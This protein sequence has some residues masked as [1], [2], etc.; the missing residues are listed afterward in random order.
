L[1]AFLIVLLFGGGAGTGYPLIELAAQILAL[2]LIVRA[3]RP[4]PSAINT[5]AS[6]T[7]ATRSV[8]LS[9]FLLVFAAAALL[10]V[11]QLVPLPASWWH[12]L[13]ARETA[14]QVYTLLGWTTR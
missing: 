5:L 2:V 7:T 9:R 6:A 10:L 8:A 12:G 14:V 11:A 1:V 4:T 3:G 13:P